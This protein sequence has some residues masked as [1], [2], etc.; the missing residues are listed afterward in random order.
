MFIFNTALLD[1]PIFFKI[2]DD[3]STNFSIC[4]CNLFIELSRTCIKTYTNA[5]IRILTDQMTKRFGDLGLF[6]YYFLII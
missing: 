5:K 4:S 2:N 6:I 3:I 1:N